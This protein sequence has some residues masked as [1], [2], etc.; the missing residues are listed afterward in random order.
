LSEVFLHLF[1]KCSSA[2]EVKKSDENWGKGYPAV[3]QAKEWVKH[4]TNSTVE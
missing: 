3:G 4:N 1:I 2:Y